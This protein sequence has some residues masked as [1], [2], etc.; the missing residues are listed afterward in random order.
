MSPPPTVDIEVRAA[1]AWLT[2]GGEASPLAQIL[3]ESPWADE[4]ETKIFAV[5]AER[6]GKIFDGEVV[7]VSVHAY[8]WLVSLRVCVAP[9]HEAIRTT[10]AMRWS[11]PVRLLWDEPLQ[12][13]KEK[14]PAVE[15]GGE[16]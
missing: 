3:A 14:A 6:L 16:G 11:I 9:S 8:P 13:E 15:G 5:L 4:W 12:L 7:S 10:P 2:E 1:A